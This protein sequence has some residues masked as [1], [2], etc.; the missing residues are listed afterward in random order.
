M[1]YPTIED[2]I[3]KTPLVALQRLIGAATTCARQRHS[4]Q[5]GGQQPGGSVKDRPA[6]R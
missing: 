6:C 3:G 2:A 1:N 5:A 4:G